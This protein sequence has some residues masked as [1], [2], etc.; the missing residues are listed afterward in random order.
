MSIREINEAEKIIKLVLKRNFIDD[1]CCGE[2]LELNLDLTLERLI[3]GRSRALA[4]LNSYWDDDKITDEQY[5]KTAN[6]IELLYKYYKQIIKNK[7]NNLRNDDSVIENIDL[8]DYID[9]DSPEAIVYF[10]LYKKYRVDEMNDE[11]REKF[12]RSFKEQYMKTVIYEEEHIEHI[13]A[14]RRR[15]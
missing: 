4:Q 10:A 11:Q 7:L 2:D 5:N 13:E 1:F 9:L 12:E 15:F 14:R 8:P 6:A 3:N